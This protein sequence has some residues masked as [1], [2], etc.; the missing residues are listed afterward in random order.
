MVKCEICGKEFENK[1]EKQSLILHMEKKH[2]MRYVKGEFIPISEIDE[3]YEGEWRLL[4]PADHFE[5][6]LIGLGYTEIQAIP[7]VSREEWEVR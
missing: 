3:P 5:R 6:K 1:R 7:G 4:S 2:G